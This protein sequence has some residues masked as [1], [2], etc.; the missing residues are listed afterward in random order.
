MD[1]KVHFRNGYVLEIR[2]IGDYEDLMYCL[3]TIVWEKEE[4]YSMFRDHLHHFLNHERLKYFNQKKRS[5]LV[6]KYYSI[7]Y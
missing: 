7:N 3:E 6:K 2:F 1:F 5:I 4:N